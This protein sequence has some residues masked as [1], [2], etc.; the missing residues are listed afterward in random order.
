MS[1]VD[2]FPNKV[3]EEPG[4]GGGNPWKEGQNYTPLTEEKIKY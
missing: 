2:R 3:R 1:L 4:E